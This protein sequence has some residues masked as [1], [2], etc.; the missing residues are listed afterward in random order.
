MN[1]FLDDDDIFDSDFEESTEN[2]IYRTQVFK[3]P[4]IKLKKS[5]HVY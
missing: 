3:K 4:H 5:V 2:D 1:N